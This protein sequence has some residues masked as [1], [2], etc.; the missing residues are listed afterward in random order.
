MT[1]PINNTG[2][3][4][5]GCLDI[6]IGN[7]CVLS[8]DLIELNQNSDKYQKQLFRDLTDSIEESFIL[9][10]EYEQNRIIWLTQ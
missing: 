3:F 7:K 10:R 8:V 5:Q 2:D 6:K 4:N 9:G 1:H